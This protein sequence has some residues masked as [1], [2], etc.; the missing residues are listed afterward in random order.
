VLTV[1]GAATSLPGDFNDDDVVNAADYVWLRKFANT[2]QNESTW[3]TH[4][5]ESQTGAS[6]AAG[7]PEP[8]STVFGLIAA[9][10]LAYVGQRQSRRHSGRSVRNVDCASIVVLL[11]NRGTISPF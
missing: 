2:S 8:E 1:L 4:F 9:C 5:G 11:V 7:V 3:R 6:P 10:G